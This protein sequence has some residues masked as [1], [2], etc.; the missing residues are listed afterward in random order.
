MKAATRVPQRSTPVTKANMPGG[1]SPLM[2]TATCATS[3]TK[4]WAMPRKM[5]TKKC[6]M[7]AMN[8]ISRMVSAAHPREL[9]SG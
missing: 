2:T 5:R 1:Y 6:G 8:L 7:R 4:N 3:A 9:R